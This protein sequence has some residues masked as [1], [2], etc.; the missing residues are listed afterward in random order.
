MT[1]RTLSHVP[2]V[3]GRKARA[4]SPPSAASYSGPGQSTVP[5]KARPRSWPPGPRRTTGEPDPR[6]QEGKAPM[7]TTR[8]TLV[9]TA[10]L[11]L[12]VGS[13]G[14]VLAQDADVWLLRLD[15]AEHRGQLDR[16][17]HQLGHPPDA[18]LGA[19]AEWPGWPTGCAIQ[20][21]GSTAPRKV[22]ITPSS[23][24]GP[25]EWTPTQCSWRGRVTIGDGAAQHR[26]RSAPPSP[27]GEPGPP[28]RLELGLFQ[29]LPSSRLPQGELS[30]PTAKARAV[31]GAKRCWPES[32]GFVPCGRRSVV[33]GALA[34]QSMRIERFWAPRDASTISDQASCP[35]SARAR[36]RRRYPRSLPESA[37]RIS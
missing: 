35:A 2:I 9:G 4:H 17:G 3:P 28:P 12:F 6:M 29:L 20:S 27:S 26:D 22:R 31:S 23:V 25:I 13:S 30:Q 5:G 8:P 10:I 37:S 7:R 11:A 19:T 15:P 36:C 24:D 14:A 32:V 18:R 16:R 1:R 34:D 33:D 21:T